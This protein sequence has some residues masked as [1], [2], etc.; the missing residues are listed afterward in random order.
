MGTLASHLSSRN[1]LS[2]QS[3]VIMLRYAVAG[4][5]LLALALAQDDGPMSRCS[6]VLQPSEEDLAKLE[7]CKPL[8]NE[9]KS[10]VD[11]GSCIAEKL[12]YLTGDGNL[13]E[14]GWISYL[15]K[16]ADAYQGDVR[17]EVVTAIKENLNE[18]SNVLEGNVA[19]IQKVVHCAIDIDSCHL[20]G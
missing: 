3:S 12:G 18:C 7:K 1:C 9:E 15:K 10:D 2:S 13:D 5:A 11:I 16:R 6:A 19:N 14:G 17:A 8:I 20:I 4:F